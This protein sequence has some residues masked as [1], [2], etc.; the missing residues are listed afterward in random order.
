[1]GNCQ[2]YKT[3]FGCKMSIAYIA[4]ILHYISK[5]CPSHIMCQGDSD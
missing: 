5:E 4:Y 2:V 1:M 3:C